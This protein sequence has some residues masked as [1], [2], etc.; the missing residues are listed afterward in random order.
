MPRSLYGVVKRLSDLVVAAV[1]ILALAPVLFVVSVA[2]KL[3]TPGPAIYRSLRVGR[4]G[5]TFAMLKFRTMVVNADRIGASSTPEDDPRITRVGRLLRR[6][7]LDELPQLI[8]VLKGDMS[9]VGPRPQVPW[10]V[11][12]YSKAERVVLTVR[13]GMTD[14]ASLAFRNE[15]EILRGSR[16]P[17]RDYLEKIHPRKMQLSIEY[18]HKAS[19]LTDVRIL[20]ATVRAVFGRGE[21]PD[22]TTAQA[23]GITEDHGRA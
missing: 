22:D 5:K 15:G 16:D 21:P 2:I 9:V 1:A 14:Y 12:L 20:L 13:P 10:A 6:Y 4:H 18:V 11:A 3:D 7:K 23:R 19:L 8:N 17:D